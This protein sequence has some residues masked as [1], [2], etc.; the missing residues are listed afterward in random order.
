MNRDRRGGDGAGRDQA[1]RDA[2]AATGAPG[3]RTRTAAAYP[4][5]ARALPD[6]GDGSPTIDDAATAAVEHKDGGVPV[7]RGVA[8]RVGGYLG[9]DFSDVRV[10]QDALAQEASAAMS[11]RAFAHG[12]DVFL[13]PGESGAELGLMAHEL[14]H[15]AQQNA[16]SRRTPLPKLEVGA[17]NSP[18]EQEADAVAAAVTGGATPALVVD[19]G[20]V[21][22]GQMLKSSFVAELRDAVTA[23]ADQELGPV[24]SALGCPYIEKYFQRY[25]ARSAAE[26]EALLRRFAPA[27]RDA[28]SAADLIP[29]VVQRVRAGVR[30]WCDTGRVPPEVAALEPSAATAAA[31]AAPTSAQALRAPDGRETLASLEADLGPGAPLDRATASRMS[32]ALGA[33]FSSVRIHS[34]AVAAAKAAD[35]GALAFAVGN[36]VVLGSGAP[37]AGSIAGDALLAHELA[38]TAQQAGALGDPAARLAP[39]EIEDSAAEAHADGV[40]GGAVAMLHAPAARRSLSQRIND[41]FSPSLKLQRCPAPAGPPLEGTPAELARQFGVSLSISPQ[42]DAGSNPAIVG[43]QVT[44]R[45]NPDVAV[46]RASGRKVQVQGWDLEG[47]DGGRFSTTFAANAPETTLPIVKPG[48]HKFWA[49]IEIDDEYEFPLEYE[50]VAVKATDQAKTLLADETAT[51]LDDYQASLLFR[52]AILTPPGAAEQ[53]AA[54]FR[55]DTSDANPAPVDATGKT[56][57]AYSLIDKHGD[58]KGRRWFA[59]PMSWDGMPE[60]LGGAKRTKLPGGVDAYDL[61]SGATARLPASHKGTFA[62]ICQSL[63]DQGQA[64]HDAR[65]LQT[66]LTNEEVKSAKELDTYVDRAMEMSDRFEGEVVPITGVHVATQ[67]AARTPLRLYLGKKKGEPKTWILLDLTPGLDP[68]RNELEFDGSKVSSVLEEFKDDNKYPTG[69]IAWRI[70]KNNLGVKERSEEFETDGESTLEKLSSW[71]GIASLALG[72]AAVVAAPF[73]G[74][75]SLLVTTLIIGSAAAGVAAG[76]LSLADHLQT[77]ETDATMVALDVATIAASFLN[78]GAALK[79]ARSGP[80]MLVAS[81]G[82]RFLLW[83]SF[84][85]DGVS[86]LLITVEGAEQISKIVDND[87]MSSS[88]KSAAIVRV[89]AN[90]VATGALMAISYGDLKQTKARVSG[91]IGAGAKGL[92]ATDHL[93][94]GMLDDTTLKQLNGAKEAELNRLIKMLR[95]DP[96]GMVRLIGKNDL[97]PALRRTTG[98]TMRDLDLELLSGRFTAKGLPEAS[99]KRIREALADSKITGA[100]LHAMDDATL[101]ALRTMDE[102]LAAGKVKDAMT[103]F[104]GAA[105][106]AKARPGIQKSLANAHG[107][108]DPGA[109]VA[110][111]TLAKKLHDNLNDRGL[112]ISIFKADLLDDEAVKKVNRA[113]ESDPMSPSAKNQTPEIAEARKRAE[114]WALDGANGDPREFANRYEYARARYSNLKRDAEKGLKGVTPP[115]GMNKEKMAGNE[116]AAKSSAAEIEADLQADIAVSDKLGP[117]SSHIGVDPA[118]TPAA[119]GAKVQKLDR[120]PY[121]SPTAEAYHA[122][123]HAKELDDLT[124]LPASDPVTRFAEATKL[125]LTKGAVTKAELSHTGSTMVIIQRS[126]PKNGG[127]SVTLEAIVYVKPD[128]R[129]VIATFGGAKAK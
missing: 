88:E 40:A 6:G 120:I 92:S 86:A 53:G 68:E 107:H 43:G 81:R 55:I 128:G 7:D 123:K 116:A 125:T 48:K 15:V 32:A 66:I 69:A 124:E 31:A 50:F 13:G 98:D 17:A 23:A 77:E 62:V 113:L 51:A 56:T 67:T 45:V 74:G 27:A 36:N 49:T 39:I 37:A 9:A 1:A 47:P 96:N 19:D 78:A 112:D 99:S 106:P 54:E 95:D 22:S 104:D 111:P 29:I 52:Q 42:V 24:F 110:D 80:A 90:L 121:E 38:H 103:A 89:L 87:S 109:H 14:T 28:R 35:V 84:A 118:D 93:T 65:Y 101:D 115:K 82:G 102:H 108:P 60:Q 3:K 72:I 97:L 46:M 70:D 91:A 34:G 57:L 12:A 2:R 5:L 73:T 127:G 33:D 105:V 85:A 114:Q 71:A 94:L 83:S 4:A 100:E 30:H 63:D 61:G 126:F 41:F 10:H 122:Q 79:A 25:G 119:I 44:F 76:A 58:G 129:V 16:G 8:E 18:A 59:K 26:I 64:L 117:G 11:A 75:G 21:A 20:P